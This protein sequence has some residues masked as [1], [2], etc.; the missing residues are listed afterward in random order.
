MGLLILTKSESENL[1]ALLE[2][3]EENESVNYQLLQ[4]IDHPKADELNEFM[5]FLFENLDELYEF[6]FRSSIIDE[7]KL[8]TY[9]NQEYFIYRT[10]F[11]SM[12]KFEIREREKEAIKN[13]NLIK[14][15]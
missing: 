10:K 6:S 4:A 12:I 9:L 5:E 3:L 13:L 14:V 15:G 1:N 11:K 8:F 2:V 7:S